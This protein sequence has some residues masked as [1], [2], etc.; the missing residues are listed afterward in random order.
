MAVIY[1]DLMELL[2]IFTVYM[3]TIQSRATKRLL[4]LKQQKWLCLLLFYVYCRR[5]TSTRVLKNSCPTILVL[6]P[7]ELTLRNS[8]TQFE[9]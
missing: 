9:T 1:F 7:S 3:K 8:L 2:Q 4:K 5:I 6:L